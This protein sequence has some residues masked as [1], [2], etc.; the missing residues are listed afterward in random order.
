[1]SKLC[2]RQKANGTAAEVRSFATPFH[3]SA[4]KAEYSA[5]ITPISSGKFK[6]SPPAK[7]LDARQKRVRRKTSFI[8]GWKRR[9]Q[10]NLPLSVCRHP[11]S[12]TLKSEAFASLFGG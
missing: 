12:M 9:R 1:M 2:Q 6:L 7:T 4:V 3:C 8:G 10:G 5:E 11:I